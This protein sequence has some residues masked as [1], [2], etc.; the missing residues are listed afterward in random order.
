MNVASGTLTA[1]TEH[2]FL[3]AGLRTEDARFC[4]EIHV[5]Q[6]MRGVTTHGL[7]HVPLVLEGLT[8]GRMNPRPAHTILHDR[9]ATIV[10]DGDNGP[11]ALGSMAA[12]DQAITKAMQFG[13]GMGIVIRNNH[14]I[15]AAPYCLRAV[16][17]GMIG[18]CCSNTWAS[19]GY[20]GTNARAIANSPIGF[21]VPTGA[22]FPIIFD[23]ALTTSGGQLA[24]WIRE[25]Q[26]I[27]PALLGIDSDGNPSANPAAVLHGGTP[28]PIGTYKGAGLAVLVE[29]LT[30]VLGGGGFLHSIE[31]PAVRTSPAHGESQCCIAIKI[32][33][34]I[35]PEEFLRRMALFV[36]DL[37]SNPL[38][39]G[40]K[41]ILLPGERAHRSYRTNLD[42]GV[43]VEEDVAAGLHGWAQQLNV[44]CPF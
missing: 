26:T 32:A 31:A 23:S 1:F 3:A 39:P 22:G 18:L 40:Y 29:I 41:E 11:G 13:V 27:P 43:P 36:A 28:Q 5:Q 17:H 37:K 16:E 20:P 38:V 14:F 19:M 34:F 9:A 10:L 35:P 25:R 12:M 15:S 2:L 8:K 33:T 4:A 44:D 6:E 24:K 30:G 21:G 42:C 7:R